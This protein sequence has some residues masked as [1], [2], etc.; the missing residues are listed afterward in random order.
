MRLA[1][2]A[3]I[4]GNLPALEAVLGDL[5]AQAPDRVL[6]AG[7]LVNRCPWNNE[8]LA[9]ARSTGWTCIAGNHEI[10]LAAMA[11]GEHP[12]LFDDRERFA[13]LWW[14]LDELTAE[15]VAFIRALPEQARVAVGD[16]PAIRMLH[17]LPGDAFVGFTDALSDSRMGALLAPI[18]E[19]V[20]ISAHTHQPLARAVTR[21]RVYNPGSV[22][23]PYN[24]DPRA[25]YLLLDL[26]GQGEA[27]RWQPTFRRL[28]Y[29][30]AVVS[31]AFRARGLL[32]AY[33]PLGPLYL[34]TVETGEPWVSDFQI[35]L[36]G[37]PMEQRSSMAAAV[38]RYLTLHGP[39]NW[40]FVPTA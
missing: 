4:H 35:W 24:G 5:A 1:I 19:S 39:G 9:L 27:A 33:G 40:A 31:A 8:V 3:D 26:V 29:D 34:R 32:M 7:D 36:R 13:D 17:G 2:L 18:R 16:G 22:G 21:W 12:T 11:D 37:V 6:V 38:A 23:M 25:H 15:H 14:T 20:V 30:R 28:A 10:V